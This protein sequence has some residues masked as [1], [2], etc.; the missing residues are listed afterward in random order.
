MLNSKSEVKSIVMK[1]FFMTNSLF[2]SKSN[3]AANLV[4]RI[5]IVLLYRVNDLLI[6]QN[7]VSILLVFTRSIFNIRKISIVVFWRL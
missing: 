7:F 1:A 4:L 2:P 6:S 3:N 5:F